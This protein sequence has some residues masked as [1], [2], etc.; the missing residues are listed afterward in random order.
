MIS[1]NHN[2]LIFMH[3]AIEIFCLHTLNSLCDHFW[4]SIWATYIEFFYK[5]LSL[6]VLF[7]LWVGFTCSIIYHA[8]LFV[9]QQRK[10]SVSFGSCKFYLYMYIIVHSETNYK[11]LIYVIETGSLEYWDLPVICSW[12]LDFRLKW[13]WTWPSIYKAHV[14]MLKTLFNNSRTQL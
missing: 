9:N 13:L 6:L 14:Y 2:I 11:L 12:I 8:Y 5:Y 4:I 3:V 10:H 7:L 1:T